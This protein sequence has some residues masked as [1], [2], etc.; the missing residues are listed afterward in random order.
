MVLSLTLALPQVPVQGF[1]RKY[2]KGV[3]SY[4]N[5]S[6]SLIPPATPP[7][8]VPIQGFNQRKGKDAPTFNLTTSLTS[9]QGFQE[10]RKRDL[11]YYAQLPAPTTN[12]LPVVPIQGLQVLKPNVAAATFS[13]P[14]PAVTPAPVVAIQGFQEITKAYPRFNVP[15]AV[16][17]IQGFIELDPH[18]NWTWA[19]P[20]SIGPIQGLQQTLKRDQGPVAQLPA[21][22]NPSP[23]PV[24]PIQGFQI[25]TP[26][27]PIEAFQLP[28]PAPPSPLPVVPVQGFEQFTKIYPRFSV[29]NPVAPIQGFVV[30][31]PNY[32]WVWSISAP[33]QPVQGFAIVQP[34]IGSANFLLPAPSALPVVAVQGFQI[35]NPL[36]PV[37]TFLLPEPTPPTP[38]PIVIP[39]DYELTSLGKFIIYFEAFG[40]GQTPSFIKNRF[41]MHVT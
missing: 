34:Q 31:A 27:I 8:V 18:L 28:A 38:D 25:V 19:I 3:I 4:S 30:V 20:Q 11:G 22:A 26:L 23:A 6:T 21:P 9:I 1:V 5:L 2:S 33:V 15:A 16:V 17:P 7:A 24:A 35:L 12:P 10:W 13:L 37:G 29:V 36:I 41:F 40:T 39:G 32:T 14:Q